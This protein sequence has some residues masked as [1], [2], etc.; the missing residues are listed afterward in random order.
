MSV[1]AA[2]KS[3][4]M[5]VVAVAVVGIIVFIVGAYIA[6]VKGAPKGTLARI[7]P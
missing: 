1:I 7:C 3:R 2:R 5:G 6:G 4:N